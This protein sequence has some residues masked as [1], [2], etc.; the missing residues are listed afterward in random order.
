V[1]HIG[2]P[3]VLA[4]EHDDLRVVVVE[5]RDERMDLRFAEAR[6]ERAVLVGRQV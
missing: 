6:R 2:L 3:A 1:P 5:L 4:L